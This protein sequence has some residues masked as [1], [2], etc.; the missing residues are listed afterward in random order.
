MQRKLDHLSQNN[1]N[2]KNEDLTCETTIKKAPASA[3]CIMPD[4]NILASTCYY[5]IDDFE[6]KGE[7]VIR[8]PIT[9]QQVK[10]LIDEP[11]SALCIMPDGNI[12][13]STCYYDID[14]YEVKGE[15]VIRNPITGK[16][17]RTLTD[18]PASALC[19][20]LDGS[21]LS[22]TC[23]YDKDDYEVKGNFKLMAWTPNKKLY[24]RSQQI[25][26][27]AV[28]ELSNIYYASIK[29]IEKPHLSM[30]P[31]EVLLLIMFEC[32]KGTL[33]MSNSDILQCSELILEN[34]S[35]RRDLIQKGEY[36]PKLELDKHTKISKTS[37]EIWKWWSQSTRD[38]ENKKIFCR[39]SGAGL[40]KQSSMQKSHKQESHKQES[41]KH[42]H[43]KRCLVM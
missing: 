29:D 4:G 43:H 34:F 8:N 16:P 41:H 22:S 31:V 7:I 21:I 24:H 2:Y 10:T 26:I 28:I 6:V 25:F 38:E 15:I 1:F 27:N 20:T 14:D 3:L 5:D 12:L 11:A 33:G 23:Y 13:A 9:G 36:N 39:T 42:N 40:F 32:G 19:F 18:K 30:L 35:V 37:K 17:I